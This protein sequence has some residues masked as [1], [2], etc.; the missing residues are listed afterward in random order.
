VSN[1]RVAIVGCGFIGQKRAR[2]M[3]GATLT[4]CCDPNVERAHQVARPSGA[5]VTTSWREAATS[6]DADVVV[7]ATTHDMLAPIATAAAAAGKHVLVEKPAARRSAELEAL[8]AAALAS[9]VMVRIGF[10]HRY[11]P[12]LQK[13]KEI[14]D[15]GCLGEL[16]FVRGRYGHGGR[17]GYDREWRADPNLSGGGEAIDQGVHLVD[18]ARWFLGDFSDV[19]GYAAT[20]FWDMPVEDN[21]FFLLRTATGQTA[22]LHASWTEWK[23]T[24]SLEV[25]GRLGKLELTGLGGSYGTERVAHYQMT[26]E[27]GPPPTFIYEYPMA[28]TSWEQE[29]REFAED[30]RSGRQPRPGIADAAAALAVVEGVYRQSGRLIELPPPA[31]VAL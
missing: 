16:M 8:A 9:G 6:P 20:Y 22:F 15:T 28:D 7:V 17:P 23:N 18:L 21:A 1:L 2:S 26:P 10:N 19:Q 29:W 27:M 31:G 4:V 25:A 12:A 11:H 13:A 24:F 3:P 30:I 5:A 14:A